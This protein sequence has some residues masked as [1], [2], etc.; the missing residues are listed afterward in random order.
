M[1]NNYGVISSLLAAKT[2]FYR[3]KENN[4]AMLD[5]ILDIFKGMELAEIALIIMIVIVVAFCLLLLSLA[6]IRRLYNARKYRVMDRLRSKYL[7]LLYKYI[8]SKTSMNQHLDRFQAHPG[9]KK[10][11]VIEDN[12]FLFSL[13]NDTNYHDVACQLFEQLGYVDYYIKVL[14]SRKVIARA[15]AIFKL[16]RMETPRS[17]KPLLAMIESENPEIISVTMHA[18]IKAGDASILLKLLTKLP[19]LL[20]KDLVTKKI[21]DSSLVA[22]GPR[23]TPILLEYGKTCKDPGMIA[24]LLEVLSTFPVNREVYDFAVAHLGHPDP[25]VR[26]KALKVIAPCEKALGILHEGVLPPLLKDPVWFVR[27]QAVRTLG[28]Q[29]QKENAQ[30]IA[31]LVLDEKW[32]VRNAAAMALTLLGEGAIDAFWTLLKSND[33]YAKESICEEMQKTYFVDLLLEL[34]TNSQGTNVVKAREILTVMAACG[35]SSP[36]KEFVATTKDAIHANEIKLIIAG[37]TAS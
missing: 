22:A 1:K 20:N 37:A 32:Q 12:L 29:Q 28:R 3:Y 26:I 21:I 16:G 27:L 7:S 5:N 14:N 6:V 13:I 8:N 2:I 25:E 15:T 33:R 31:D 36:L 35:F 24:S 18:L 4:I 17:A 23:I 11:I 10:W 34:L 30:A 9:S 19:A